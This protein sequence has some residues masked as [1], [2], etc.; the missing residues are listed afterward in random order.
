M[1]T[2]ILLAIFGRQDQLRAISLFAFGGLLIGFLHMFVEVQGK[3]HYSIVTI[4]PVI[5]SLFLA[6]LGEVR[7][8]SLAII[9]K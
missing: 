7:R 6:Y 9:K 3:Y 5:S 2:T 8:I 4:F 1:L